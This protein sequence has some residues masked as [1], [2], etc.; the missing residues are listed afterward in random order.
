MFFCIVFIILIIMVFYKKKQ[1]KK[2][3]KI[4][5]M[6]LKT[7][8]SKDICNIYDDSNNRW[9]LYFTKTNGRII[10]LVID[11]QNSQFYLVYENGTISKL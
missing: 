5:E 3:Q 7:P 1:E 8:F 10:R 4:V 2:L 6:V 9:L 11:I